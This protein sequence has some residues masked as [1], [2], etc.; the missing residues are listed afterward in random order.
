MMTPIQEEMLRR[1]HNLSQVDLDMINA[2]FL[3][4]EE[5]LHLDRKLETKENEKNET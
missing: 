3:T 1:H 4:L 5:I 2:G